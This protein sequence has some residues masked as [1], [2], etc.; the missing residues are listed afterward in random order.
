MQVVLPQEEVET[1]L[2]EALAARG[3][4][5]PVGTKMDYR[6]NNK[7]GTFKI[8]FTGPVQPCG[9]FEGSYTGGAHLRGCPTGLGG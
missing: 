7:H 1:L 2:R 8:V 4:R 6:R 3:I 9:C 5:L